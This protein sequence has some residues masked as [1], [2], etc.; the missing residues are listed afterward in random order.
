MGIIA[1]TPIQLRAGRHAHGHGQV[2]DIVRNGFVLI[3]LVNSRGMT[4]SE[5]LDV[6]GAGLLDVRVSDE[7]TWKLA[8]R[9]G[10]DGYLRILP[11]IGGGRSPEG[12]W[13]DVP[14]DSLPQLYL[15]LGTEFGLWWTYSWQS[16]L[17]EFQGPDRRITRERQLHRISTYVAENQ[18]PAFEAL[19]GA[20]DAVMGRSTEAQGA[21]FRSR[22][23]REAAQTRREWS[24]HINC[25][26]LLY[27]APN[28]RNLS[29]RT[30][31]QADTDLARR[32]TLLNERR[33]PMEYAREL[34]EFQRVPHVRVEDDLLQYAWE[35]ANEIHRCLD[36]IGEQDIMVHQE[37]AA[38]YL[39]IIHGPDGHW[40]NDIISN[41]ARDELIE[42]PEWRIQT[43]RTTLST[44]P[45]DLRERIVDAGR[46]L[47]K[48]YS[49]AIHTARNHYGPERGRE[50]IEYILNARGASL[51][52]ALKGVVAD[53][54]STARAVALI[55]AGTIRDEGEPADRFFGIVG[56]VIDW[57][58]NS[59][60]VFQKTC[61]WLYPLIDHAARARDG[62]RAVRNLMRIAAA[63]GRESEAGAVPMSHADFMEIRIGTR[64]IRTSCRAWTAVNPRLEKV[65]YVLQ[66]I[67]AVRAMNDVSK[68]PDLQHT[69]SAAGSVAEL[70]A[71][72]NDI[73]AAFYSRYR[74]P[75]PFVGGVCMGYAAMFDVAD[76]ALI[77]DNVGAFGY[78]LQ[79]AAAFAAPCVEG[80]PVGVA[81]AAAIL[82]GAIVIAYSRD[83]QENYVLMYMADGGLASLGFT[84]QHKA[85]VFLRG[86]D[87]AISLIRD[88]LQQNGW[89]TA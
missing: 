21:E 56:K 6:S 33:H 10:A 72:S 35:L 81:L 44:I 48:I 39:R 69:L 9:T 3:D 74:V 86:S 75:L 1:G 7:I 20:I 51:F 28:Y 24:Q 77:G 27:W 41:A 85:E 2:F 58:G 80:G 17:A 62:E 40:I 73:K 30:M 67:N 32:L 45:Q 37:A 4:A 88:S 18:L 55:R 52:G 34:D 43:L 5:V 36:F 79:G 89:V 12:A 76:R 70:A 50:Y 47:E 68:N 19:V 65:A 53:D 66:V 61:E 15:N 60:T 13:R 57:F 71:A 59:M 8:C 87:H 25:Y 64:M 23:V 14:V 26:H 82:L 46:V 78:M 22:W 63:I 29:D 16:F 42:H 54:S 38:K 11:P 83:E 31:D 49:E 84:I